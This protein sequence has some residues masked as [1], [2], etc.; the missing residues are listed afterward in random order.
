MSLH[1]IIRRTYMEIVNNVLWKKKY[2]KQNAVL[3]SVLGKT[4]KQTKLLHLELR[5]SINFH[6]H[7]NLFL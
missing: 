4:V 1:N 5:E 7:P 6:P 2:E 3:A